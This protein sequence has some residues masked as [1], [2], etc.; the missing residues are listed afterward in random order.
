MNEWDVI[1]RALRDHG[2]LMVVGMMIGLITSLSITFLTTPIYEARMVVAPTQR[3]G[4]PSLGSLLPQQISE[5]PVLQYFVNRID[6]A[7]TSDFAVFEELID[8]PR[9]AQTMIEKNIRELPATSA[10]AL[11]TWIDKH[12]TIRPVGTSPFRRITL[13]HSDADTALRLL[14]TIF[15]ETD[16]MIRQDKRLETARRITYLTDQLEKTRHPDHQD[17]IIALL[18]EQEQIAMMVSIDNNFAARPID[19]PTVKPD[20]VFPNP[21]LIIPVFIFGGAVI[22]FMIS[23]LWGA[24]RRQ[25]P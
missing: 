24:L 14:R 13:R 9:L 10:S 6:A 12:V 3:T 11:T 8:S 4:M 25:E 15:Q 18:K 7:D 16:M 20:P 21:M 22:G 5:T 17:A 2:R 1:L 23:G 19:P